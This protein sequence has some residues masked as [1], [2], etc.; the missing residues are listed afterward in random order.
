[1][2]IEKFV[3]TFGGGSYSSLNLARLASNNLDGDLKKKA[4]NLLKTDAEFMGCLLEHN[5]PDEKVD[6]NTLTVLANYKHQLTN[7]STGF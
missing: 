3:S 7:Y 6:K 1:M 5:W 2:T 4:E